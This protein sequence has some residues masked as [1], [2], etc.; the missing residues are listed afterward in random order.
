[1]TWFWVFVGGGLGSICRY[2]ISLLLKTNS[3]SFPWATL[4][5][6]FIS[7]AILAWLIFRFGGKM[8]N[9]SLKLF[10]LTGF[11]GGFSTFSTFSLESFSLLQSNF[12]WGVANIVV[13]VL[14]GVALVAMIANKA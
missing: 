10:L 9:S 11:C 7:T 1:M 2:G 8:E 12:W 4:L 3:N 5:S 14:G 13:S 6:N